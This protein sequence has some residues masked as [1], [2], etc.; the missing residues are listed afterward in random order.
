MERYELRVLPQP[1][2]RYAVEGSGLIDGGMFIIS[3][4]LNPEAVM[5][6][7]AHREGSSMPAWHYGFARIAIAEI[8]VAFEDKEIWS[9]RGGY[10]RGPD[11][12]YWTFVKPIEGE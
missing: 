8:H 9:H 12:P 1:V 7:E 6:V 2:Y 4:G 10:S 3:Y 11:D 5:L